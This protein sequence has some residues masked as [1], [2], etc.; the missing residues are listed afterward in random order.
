MKKAMLITPRMSEKAYAAATSG[1]YVFNVPDEANKHEVA[2]AVGSQYGVTV[3]DV[4]IVRSKGKNV[5]TH[6]G[7][8]KFVNGTRKDTKKAYVRLSEGESIPVFEE[9]K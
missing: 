1:A 7:R 6:R 9:A 2:T 3:T 5:R 4:R 8:G